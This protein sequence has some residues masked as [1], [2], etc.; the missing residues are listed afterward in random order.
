[1]P[2]TRITLERTSV[3]VVAC[4]FC[5]LGRPRGRLPTPRKLQR[6][7]IEP[8]ESIHVRSHLTEGGPQHNR[9][10]RVS[11]LRFD[12]PRYH[13]RP[14]EFHDWPPEFHPHLFGERNGAIRICSHGTSFANIEQ[15]VGGLS[16]GIELVIEL[17]YE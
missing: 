4:L 5:T 14:Q 6:A 16:G 9:R 11:C 10:R 3:T 1:M 12:H 17:L 2:V 7:A 15:I 8:R 13:H